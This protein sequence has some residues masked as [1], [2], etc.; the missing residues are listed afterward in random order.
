MHAV[1]L[2]KARNLNAEIEERSD[3]QVLPNDVNIEVTPR[4]QAEGV[5]AN[6]VHFTVPAENR[7][8]TGSQDAVCL[9]SDFLAVRRHVLRSIG[10][11]PP[12]VAVRLSAPRRA[13]TMARM[14]RHAPQFYA[15]IGG[16]LYLLIIAAGLFAEALVRNR[17]VVPGD[18]AVRPATS[19]TRRSCFASASPPISPRSCAPSR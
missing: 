5:A 17:L 16:V 1:R 10:S 4:H 12:V 19:R 18:A 6:D 2:Q 7:L 14:L 11:D 13:A 8:N 9:A 15:R 3:V